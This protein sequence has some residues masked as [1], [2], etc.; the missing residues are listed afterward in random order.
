MATV[1]PPICLRC[2][3]FHED[4]HERFTCDAFPKAIPMRIV[5]SEA[6]HRKP[7]PGD[8]GIRYEQAPRVK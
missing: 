6:D 1:P 5:R 3:H 8:H 2:A 4:D 7:F